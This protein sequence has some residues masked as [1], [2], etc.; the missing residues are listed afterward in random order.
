MNKQTRGLTTYLNRVS[1]KEW[2]K[3]RFCDDGAKVV[4][5]RWRRKS[6]EFDL[7]FLLGSLLSLSK[8]KET[9]T[10]LRLW[11]GSQGASLAVSGCGLRVC[12]AISAGTRN[13]HSDRPGLGE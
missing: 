2:G 5:R 1:A 7:I 4:R 11:T 12:R 8:S 10:S 9:R 13:G 3:R 6:G